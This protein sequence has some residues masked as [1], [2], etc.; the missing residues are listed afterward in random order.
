MKRHRLRFRGEKLPLAA[1]RRAI[2]SFGANS[3]TAE[4]KSRRKG[5]LLSWLPGWLLGRTRHT[6]C[7]VGI[8]DVISSVR[9]TRREVLE[10]DL[11]ETRLVHAFADF[12]VHDDRPTLTGEIVLEPVTPV[13]LQESGLLELGGDFD[14][15]DLS[16][17]VQAI[18]PVIRLLRQG[19]TPVLIAQIR[20]Y[21]LPHA[22]TLN[23]LKELHRVTPGP[24][25]SEL[26]INNSIYLIYIFVNIFC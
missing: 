2:A 23:N 21:R 26:N 17:V 3:V 11:H 13:P 15:V 1:A 20:E 16:I 8:L 25:P 7:S 6:D 5:V 19:D 14:P 24:R 22:A 9:C 18:K 10:I 12:L 4:R